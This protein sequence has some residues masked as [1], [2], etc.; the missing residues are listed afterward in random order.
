MDPPPSDVPLV[1]TV[2]IYMCSTDRFEICDAGYREKV[3]TP[4]MLVE[5]AK[6]LQKR[7][8]L[9]DEK[10]ENDKV[11]YCFIFSRFTLADSLCCY[12]LRCINVA[13]KNDGTFIEKNGK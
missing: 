11:N 6:K 9:A 13:E 8:Q 1:S 7:K 4:E 2:L 5:K 3:I 10:R 12:N